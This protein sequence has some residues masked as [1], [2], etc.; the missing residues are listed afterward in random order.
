M[1]LLKELTISNLT[2][3]DDNTELE[4]KSIKDLQ[5]L[6]SKGAE[7]SGEW[8][9]A[10]ELVHKAYKLSNIER[11]TPDMSS[12]WKQYETMISYSVTQLSKFQGKTGNWRMTSE[13]FIKKNKYTIM[14]NSPEVIMETLDIEASNIQE[15]I[16]YFKPANGI[17]ESKI[18]T[19]GSTLVEFWEY[20]TI[21]SKTF[22]EIIKEN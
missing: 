15:I 8:A 3:M 12:A 1:N 22:L 4:P 19:S 14:Y 18:T 7:N 13:S 9:N 11:P 21:K 16:D 17:Q 20:G 5:S 6:I 10:L 2:E